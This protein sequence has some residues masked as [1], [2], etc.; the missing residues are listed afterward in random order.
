MINPVLYWIIIISVSYLTLGI[1]VGCIFIITLNLKVRV[2]LSQ[3]STIRNKFAYFFIV[4]LLWP[5]CVY[6]LMSILESQFS[7]IGSLLKGRGINSKL[8]KKDKICKIKTIYYQDGVEKLRELSTEEVYTSQEILYQKDPNDENK[9]QL[10]K[11]VDIIGISDQELS[12]SA[13]IDIDFDNPITL[14]FTKFI[15]ENGLAG[16][17]NIP[18]NVEKEFIIGENGTNISLVFEEDVLACNFSEMNSLYIFKPIE[19]TEK[20]IKLQNKFINEF[21]YDKENNILLI[22]DYSNNESYAIQGKD[23]QLF[24][25]KFTGIDPEDNYEKVKYGDTILNYHYNSSN[26]LDSISCNQS[27]DVNYLRIDDIDGRN[28]TVSTIT[29]PVPFVRSLGKIHVTHNDYKIYCTES[30]TKYNDVIE[31]RV[32]EYRVFTNKEEED[33]KI[34]FKRTVLNIG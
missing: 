19:E 24:S 20:G 27:E 14:E 11:K 34:A 8:M 26:E 6:K 18:A 2:I 5:V 4:S 1:I 25:C 10:V 30:I 13:P 32:K 7:Y 12:N 15:K 31:S 29:Y 16:L 22:I 3:Y 33:L 9:L 23:D 21:H 17:E 28:N